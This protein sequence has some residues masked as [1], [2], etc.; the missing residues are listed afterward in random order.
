MKSIKYVLVFLLLIPTLSFA[1]IVFE[2]DFSSGLWSTTCINGISTSAPNGWTGSRC[3]TGETLEIVS[4]VGVG[5][6]NALR[7]GYTAG[8]TANAVQLFK[9]LTG[10]QNTGYNELYIR[11]KFRFSDNWKWYIDGTAP[12]SSAYWKWM[13]L[14][15]NRD[16]NNNTT[17]SE[18]YPTSTTGDTRYILMELASTGT[19]RGCFHTIWSDNV[20]GNSASGAQWMADWNSGTPTET[21]GCFGGAGTGTTTGWNAEG[22]HIQ[23]PGDPYP[24][25]FTTYPLGSQTW[26]TI[27]WH[28][29]LS[30]T[31]AGNGIFQMWL[32]GNLQDDPDRGR[33]LNGATMASYNTISY[34]GGI[35]L[36]SLFDNIAGITN[37]WGSTPRYIYVDNV[38]ISSSYIGPNYVISSSPSY[39]PVPPLADMI[40]PA[41]P[42]WK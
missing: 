33:A 2:D 18:N 25:Y 34:N 21:Q 24:G 36:L 3:S 14:W 4:G 26:H 42:Q 30:T 23:Q 6:K 40:P 1:T 29:K 28:V 8:S 11:Y 22:L 7:I 12:T 17:W 32:D 37:D 5:G 31:Q 39:T 19:Y 9:H 20:N 15:Q 10:N 41:P 38:A 35:N 13:R 27:E 16:P